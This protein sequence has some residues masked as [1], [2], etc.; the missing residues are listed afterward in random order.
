MGFSILA[1]VSAYKQGMNRLCIGLCL[2]KAQLYKHGMKLGTYTAFSTLRDGWVPHTP[3]FGEKNEAL[4]FSVFAKVWS[5]V[6]K[7]YLAWGLS[8]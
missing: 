1:T 7:A 6:L 4:Q 5:R 2:N 3:T 8:Q